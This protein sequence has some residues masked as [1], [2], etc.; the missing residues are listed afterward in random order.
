MKQLLLVQIVLKNDQIKINKRSSQNGFKESRTDALSELGRLLVKQK[1]ALV[2]NLKKLS[3]NDQ[4]SSEFSQ[5]YN[6]FIC[7]S[8][9]KPSWIFWDSVGC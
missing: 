3:S 1:L 2:P 8:L 4:P 5:T 9:D 6:N 7:Y